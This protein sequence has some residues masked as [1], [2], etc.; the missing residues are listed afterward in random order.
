MTAKC[1]FF[2]QK[3]VPARLAKT[4][5]NMQR[6][7]PK[8]CRDDTLLTVGFSLRTGW[9]RVPKSRRD[10]TPSTSLRHRSLSVVETR[11]SLSMVETQVSSLRDYTYRPALRT[12]VGRSP[13]GGQCSVRKCGYVL[14]CYHTAIP[15]GLFRRLKPRV[16]KV[17]S[18]RDLRKLPFRYRR[19]KPT[20]NKV[21]SLRDYAGAVLILKS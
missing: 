8:S 20:V 15:T 9:R 10:D 19:L 3:E 18:L 4:R 21:S 6:P 2:C 17:S 5:A 11:R 14:R 12:G 13:N 7:C 1:N 16:N